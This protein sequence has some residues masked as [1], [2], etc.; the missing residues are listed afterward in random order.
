MFLNSRPW[1]L[2][3][4]FPVLLRVQVQTTADVLPYLVC[5]CVS[6][7]VCVFL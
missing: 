3:D 4:V 5:V 1:R 2:H 6:E 7:S